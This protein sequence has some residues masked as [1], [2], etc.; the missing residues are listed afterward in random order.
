MDQEQR[1]AETNAA[2]GNDPNNA[3][4]RIA[5]YLADC[6]D[7]GASP[8]GA[9]RHYR[10]AAASQRRHAAG[11]QRRQAQTPK[12]KALAAKALAKAKFHDAVRAFDDG[13]HVMLPPGAEI[14]QLG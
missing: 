10:R 11:E 2:S 13:A 8:Y 9:N 1:Y 3:P 14:T 5:N 12:G 6:A 4:A 7:R